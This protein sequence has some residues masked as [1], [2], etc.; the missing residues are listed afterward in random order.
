LP[1][2]PPPPGCPRHEPSS[3]DQTL[4]SWVAIRFEVWVSVYDHS[5]CVVFRVVSDQGVLR[6][7]CRIEKLK[8][9][10]DETKSSTTIITTTTTTIIIIIII[11]ILLLK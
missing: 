1:P 7:L 2:L 10:Q 5:V 6:T 3:S 9:V 11:I 4:G 8:S